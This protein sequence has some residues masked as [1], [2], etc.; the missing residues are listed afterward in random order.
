MA[1]AAWGA[2]ARSEGAAAAALEAGGSG[3]AAAE[4]VAVGMVGGAVGDAAAE[5][6]VLA[7][8][9]SAWRVG[10]EGKQPGDAYLQLN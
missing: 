10:R 2:L 8:R 4:A 1:R 6:V 5:A 9:A 7:E 3:E